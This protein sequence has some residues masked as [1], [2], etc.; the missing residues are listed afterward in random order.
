MGW[1]SISQNITGILFHARFTHFHGAVLWRD[2]KKIEC[3]S[4]GG[5]YVEPAPR[6]L[7][8]YIQPQ[9]ALAL[10]GKT[11]RM[12]PLGDVPTTH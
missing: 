10:L 2:T 12:Y 6:F 1:N 11:P 3:Q 5:Q 4:N 9:G 7:A 8:R